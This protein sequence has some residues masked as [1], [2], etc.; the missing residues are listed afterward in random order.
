MT[1]YIAT[2]EAETKKRKKARPLPV[3]R[4]SMAVDVRV[5]RRSKSVAKPRSDREKRSK[6][7]SL[8][9]HSSSVASQKSRRS[10]RS[11]VYS[12]SSKEA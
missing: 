6:S 7:F 12:Q 8:A 2:R 10:R 3:D 5:K 1:D 11:A 9:R 4:Y